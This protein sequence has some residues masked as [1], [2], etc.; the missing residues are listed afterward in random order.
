MLNTKTI[1][2]Q[3]VVEGSASLPAQLYSNV[4]DVLFVSVGA[5]VRLIR[6]LM[7]LLAW[8]IVQWASS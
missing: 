3:N 7:Y 6:T 4:P 1:D 5:R 8:L 2:N